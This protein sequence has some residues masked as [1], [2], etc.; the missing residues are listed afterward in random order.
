[1]KTAIS[2]PDPVFRSAEQLAKRLKVSRSQLYATA[3]ADYIGRSHHNDVTKKLDEVHGAGSEGLDPVLA[4][5]QSRSVRRE[6]W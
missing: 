5:I 1:M 6:R 4:H 3:V 2:I